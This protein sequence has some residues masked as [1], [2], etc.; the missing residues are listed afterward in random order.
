M[1][2]QLRV[3]IDL[4]R[5]V[6][7][8]AESMGVARTAIAKLAIRELMEKWKKEDQ[9]EKINHSEQDTTPIP[10]GSKVSPSPALVNKGVLTNEQS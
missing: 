4:G 1:L 2:I 7:F 8:Y 5:E 3:P 9:L 10:T 6:K